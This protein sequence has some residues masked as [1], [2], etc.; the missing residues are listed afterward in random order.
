MS[1]RPKLRNATPEADILRAELAQLRA[2]NGAFQRHILHQE[3]VLCVMLKRLG[4]YVKIHEE[5]LARFAAQY[6]LELGGE[7]ELQIPTA[8]NPP[9]ATPQPIVFRLKEKATDELVEAR[10][11]NMPQRVV[12]LL[13]AA[14]N[15]C[16]FE[17]IEEGTPMFALREAAR[18]L[19]GVVRT[20]IE[21]TR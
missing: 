15:A 8:D 12:D 10:L 3:V 18:S 21:E 14:Q 6:T 16:D 19:A 17:V 20:D 5:A 7:H 13:E 1:N 9:H 11:Q 2:Q 4:G